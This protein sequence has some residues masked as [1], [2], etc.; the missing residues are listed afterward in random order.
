MHFADLIS[1]I[2]PTLADMGFAPSRI[3]EY[4]AEFSKGTY[5]MRVEGEPHYPD[6]I[7]MSIRRPGGAVFELGL[8]A[9]VISPS[10][11]RAHCGRA[12][13]AESKAQSVIE[14]LHFVSDHEEKIFFETGPIE[15]FYRTAAKE[16]MASLG[17]TLGVPS[18]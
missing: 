15:D 4:G 7:A 12:K 10:W 11:Y 9:Q 1:Q 17:L 5:S 14:M 18:P 16:R 3:V 8:L 6:S 2:S 13:G